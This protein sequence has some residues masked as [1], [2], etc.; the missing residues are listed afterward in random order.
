MER[1]LAAARV[2]TNVAFRNKT[3]TIDFEGDHFGGT[4]EV[5]VE[6]RDPWRI[7]TH[8]VCDPTLAPVSTWFSQ[9]RYLCL[10]SR[11]Q[12]D[13]SNTLY[14]EPF[15]GET[16]RQDNLLGDGSYPACF[17]GLHVWLDKGLVSTKVKMHPIL[18]WGCWIHSA[19][20]NGSSN[21]GSALVGFV[22]MPDNIHQIDP[23]TLKGSARS[24]YDLLKCMIY[25]G[26]CEIVMAPLQDRSHHG[27]ALRFGD[28][29]IQVAHR[30]F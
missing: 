22:K 5:D 25:R 19:T 7:I 10:H 30:G 2:I 6:F 16:W 29:V 23:R 9:E 27:K 17:L 4:Y 18:I 14:D 20:R 26:V 13:Q 8:W 3:L 12:V 15:M 11:I 21:G 24:E 1:V 28:G